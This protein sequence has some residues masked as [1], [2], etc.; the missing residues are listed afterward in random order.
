MRFVRNKE[1]A[2]SF[3]VNGEISADEMLSVLK[4]FYENPNFEI[5]PKKV[6]KFML[7]FKAPPFI[8]I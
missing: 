6:R 4:P 5:G 8:D 1:L 3:I 2:V 7:R